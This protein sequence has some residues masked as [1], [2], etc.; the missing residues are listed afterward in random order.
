MGGCHELLSTTASSSSAVETAD[1]YARG[2][3]R[4]QDFAEKIP[5]KSNGKGRRGK[6][7]GVNT[8]CLLRYQLKAMNAAG[9]EGSIWVVSTRSR[10]VGAG[11]CAGASAAA[12]AT[13]K[14]AT[15][16]TS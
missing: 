16:K 3:K 7:V 1:C 12:G 5:S 8:E 15:V 4:A 13:N 2:K 10:K 6:I 9:K 11:A 14:R